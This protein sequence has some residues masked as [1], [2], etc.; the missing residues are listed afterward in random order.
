MG[1]GRQINGG[2]SYDPIALIL[3]V[4]LKLEIYMVEPL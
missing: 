1:E 4:K 2:L 3:K